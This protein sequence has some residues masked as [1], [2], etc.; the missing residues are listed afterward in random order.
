MDSITISETEKEY[1]IFKG[2]SSRLNEILD[3]YTAKKEIDKMIDELK[4]DLVNC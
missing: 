2:L 1:E 3:D 4:N